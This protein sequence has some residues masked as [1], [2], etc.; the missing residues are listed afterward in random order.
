MPGGPPSWRRARPL[1]GVA[2][3]MAVTSGGIRTG[4]A[5]TPRRPGPRRI[6][7]FAAVSARLYHGFREHSISSAADAAPV[8][9]TLGLVWVAFRDL[10]RTRV[11]VSGPP[12]TAVP[13]Y[14]Q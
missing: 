9:L 2:D 5:V 1:L 10:P 8:G 6:R 12:V 4:P 13:R 11:G 7:P 14:A 3:R